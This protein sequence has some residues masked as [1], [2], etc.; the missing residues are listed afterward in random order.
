VTA[1][2]ILGASQM[3]RWEVCPGSV[4][5]CATVEKQTNPYAEE[6]TRVHD[7][8]ERFMRGELPAQEFHEQSEETRA[9][10]L[11]YQEA[12]S[13]NYDPH[14]G[15]VLH[16]EQRFSLEEV[17]P[18]CF[19]TSD[20]VVWNPKSRVLFIYDYK[21]GT[22]VVDPEENKQLLYYALGSMVELKYQPLFVELVI[23]QPRAKTKNPVRRW[24]CSVS[25]LF[26][27]EQELV[28]AAAATQKKHEA[29]PTRDGSALLLLRC[30]V[31]L[32]EA[33]ERED[34]EGTRGIWFYRRYL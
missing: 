33:A 17:F 12:I 10:L 29:C 5:L 22:S 16:L 23:I 3:H 6:G 32:P 25:R 20:A 8:C 34:G 19:G 1:H 27:F 31:H 13:S 30:E 15:C 21:N 11:L 18:G 28:M 7:L 26:E 14:H 2:S 9:S 24:R 4:A